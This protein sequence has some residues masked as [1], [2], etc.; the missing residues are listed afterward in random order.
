MA[1]VLTGNRAQTIT[2][3]AGAGGHC[4]PCHQAP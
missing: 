3:P 4:P 2:G 1:V